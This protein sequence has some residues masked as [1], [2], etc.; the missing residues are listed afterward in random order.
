MQVLLEKRSAL[1]PLDRERTWPLDA[2]MA[3]FVLEAGG[4]PAR[5]LPA[6]MRDRSLERQPCR[7]IARVCDG[8]STSDAHTTIYVR[9][10]AQQHIG[11]ISETDLRVGK[12]IQL[13]CVDEAG[14]SFQASCRIGRSRP[15]MSGWNEGVLHL[16]D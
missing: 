3:M 4:Q 7:I 6:V 1:V 5:Q 14:Q 16:C 9:D 11:Y 12:F 2:R 8:D 10:I 13:C 15:F